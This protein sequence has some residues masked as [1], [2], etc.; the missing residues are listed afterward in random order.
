MSEKDQF[1]ETAGESFGYARQYLEQQ[2][3][4][5]KL[6]FAEKTSLVISALLTAVVQ[7]MAVSFIVGFLTLA[8]GF[9]LGQ[10]TGSYSTA[11]LIIA[12]IY[13]LIFS[14]VYFFRRTLLTNPILKLVITKIFSD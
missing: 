2:L 8:L 7:I 14:V 9:Y 11:F 4:Y 12:G 3:E 5:M 6:E 13:A 10:V 1:M